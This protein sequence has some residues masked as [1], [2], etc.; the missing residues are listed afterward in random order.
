[1]NSTVLPSFQFVMN[2]Q[3]I[4]G[5]RLKWPAYEDGRKLEHRCQHGLMKMR[6]SARNDISRTHANFARVHKCEQNTAYDTH[7]RY[8]TL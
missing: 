7:T 3:C 5:A 6:E 1:M 4:T 8:N 2:C